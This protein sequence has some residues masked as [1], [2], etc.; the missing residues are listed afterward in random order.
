[1]KTLRKLGFL[2]TPL[3]LVFAPSVSAQTEA[4]EYYQQWIDY[5]NGEVSVAFERTPLQFALHAFQAR[6]GFQIVV[7]STSEARL[8]SLRL[9]RQPLEPAVRSLISTIG[10]QNFAVMYDDRGR[11]HRAVVLGAQPVLDLIPTANADL[12][13]GPITIEERDQIKKDLDRWNELKQDERGR[14]EDRLKT[15][16]PSDD[17]EILVKEYGRQL[18]GIAK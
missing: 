8:V 7:P 10:Y 18:L 6:T 14:I 1:M 5:R 11:P 2:L 9:E 12:A 13:A 15:L 4:D 16:A 3:A 17:R